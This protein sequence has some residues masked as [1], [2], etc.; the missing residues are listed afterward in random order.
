MKMFW[1]IGL[2]IKKLSSQ[3]KKSKNG[4]TA[5]LFSRLKQLK[6]NKIDQIKATKL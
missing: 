3:S 2:S 6:S 4:Q 1:K 5:L